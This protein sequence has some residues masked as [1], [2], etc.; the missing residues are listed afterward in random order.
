MSAQVNAAAVKA[1]RERLARGE[2]D[3]VETD[4]E[5]LR[6]RNAAKFERRVLRDNA[7]LKGR[8]ARGPRPC[9]KCGKTFAPP[10]PDAKYCGNAC[11]QGAYRER[12][13]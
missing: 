2:S 5:A 4:F 13:S 3:F 8:A 9:A 6:K 11:R 10:R 1:A 7:D 12:R